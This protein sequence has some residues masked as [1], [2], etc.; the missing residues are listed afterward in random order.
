[1]GLETVEFILNVEAHFRVDLPEDVASNCTT[2]ADLQ[3]CIVD[4]L[5]RKGRPPSADLE[6]EVYADLVNII[7][8]FTDMKA[9]DI[10]PES[11]WVEDVTR[12]G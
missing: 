4:L 9:S 7:V 2:A 12:Y 11:R 1:M 10:R 3:R 5:V 8:G 6:A